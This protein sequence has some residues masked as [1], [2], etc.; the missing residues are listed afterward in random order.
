MAEEST[1]VRVAR[2]Y[3][4][5]LARNEDEALRRMA[6][7]WARMERTLNSEFIALAQEI[8]DLEDSGTP[9][10]KEM[11]QYRRRYQ[12]M[13][14]LVDRYM[15]EYDNEA[16][17]VVTDYQ[18]RNWNLGLDSAKAQI[19][20]ASEKSWIWNE[21]PKDAVEVVA[22][23]AGNGAPLAE[24]MKRDYGA[25]AS[26]VTDALIDGIGLG[27]GAFATAD[28]MVDAMGME[29]KRAVRIARTEIN[30]TYRLANAEQYKK[31]GVVEKVL[32]LCYPPT[33]C[34]AC[35]MMDGEECPNGMCDDHPNGKCTT[36]AVT[37]GGHYPDWQK[38]SDW[39]MAQD[40]KTQREIMGDARYE[41]W[42]KDGVPLRD[43]VTMKDNPVWGGSPSILSINDIKQNI[44][45][46]KISISLP[47]VPQ[48]KQDQFD[49]DKVQHSKDGERLISS[50]KARNVE[51]RKV[52]LYDT[53]PSEEE[54]IKR[55]GGGDNTNG[56]CVSLAYAYAGNKNGMDVIDFRGGASQRIMAI[57][58]DELVGLTKA[59]SSVIVEKGSTL[60]P[61]KALLKKV[62]EGKEYILSTGRHAAIV[63]K[64]A[65]GKLQYLELQSATRSGWH[66]FE[67]EQVTKW[68][69][70]KRT[71]SD[72]LKSRFACGRVSAGISYLQEISVFKDDDELRDILGYIN[73]EADKQQK[74]ASGSVK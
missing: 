25:L 52:S 17:R 48:T 23:F 31:S 24:L 34:F 58:E 68:G 69:T 72:T 16:V 41:M 47:T 66:D 57:A 11:I 50:F 73:T 9:V 74:G 33:A 38:G 42:K 71:L 14:A 49:P 35:L 55:L 32:R 59:V 40:E 26:D 37:I 67:Y 61:A 12:E 43:M 1:V 8:R 62:E 28:K 56:S 70:Y 6:R 44:Q 46:G 36:I 54:I 19:R 51:Y 2:E 3:R 53:Q 63:R 30:R 7:S 27:L 5:Q 22:G 15:V 4:E 10:P 29:Y 13:M 21:V 45:S 39:L 64:T 60:R 20:G 18:R 65:E